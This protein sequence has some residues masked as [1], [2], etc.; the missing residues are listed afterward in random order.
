MNEC[1]KNY[2][3]NLKQKDAEIDKLKNKIFVSLK[4]NDAHKLRLENQNKSILSDVHDLKT[5][6]KVSLQ[7]ERKLKKTKTNTNQIGT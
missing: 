1:N 6:L 7:N 2:S 4:E 3:V 5:L